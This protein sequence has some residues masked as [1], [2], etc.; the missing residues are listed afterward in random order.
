MPPRRQVGKCVR[1]EGAFQGVCQRRIGGGDQSDRHRDHDP[2]DPDRPHSHRPQHPR[3]APGRDEIEGH[4]RRDESRRSPPDESHPRLPEAQRQQAVDVP[5]IDRGTQAA[6]IRAW[7]VSS[8][9]PSKKANQSNRTSAGSRSKDRARASATRTTVRRRDTSGL[10]TGFAREC[11]R[12][13]PD[14]P[15]RNARRRSGHP[16]SRAG[17]II[18]G[19]GRRHRRSNR[20]RAQRRYLR[21]PGPVG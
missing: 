15:N 10:R 16:R 20:P 7:T 14:R 4:A 9:P 11:A 19:R 17:R 21:P 1:Q 12:A 5:E 3:Q 18:L 2:G 6:P 13:D 8:A